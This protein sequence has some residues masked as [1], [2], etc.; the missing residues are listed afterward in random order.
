[1]PTE[2]YLLKRV[3]SSGPILVPSK[4]QDRFPGK[5]I[6]AL[7][8]APPHLGL[9][10]LPHIV[11]Y[12]SLWVKR[13]PLPGDTCDREGEAMPAPAG[14][15]QGLVAS[16][17]RCW[18]EVAVRG[19]RKAGFWLWQDPGQTRTCVPAKGLTRRRLGLRRG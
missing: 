11:V 19:H 14:G 6:N 9:C 16:G 7:S 8:K 13:V 15:G 10:L 17:D 5:P 2:G 12:K 1:M 3:F 4:R 18:E